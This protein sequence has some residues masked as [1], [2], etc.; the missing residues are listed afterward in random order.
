MFGGSEVTSL[1]HIGGFDEI[2]WDGY[3]IFIFLRKG[4]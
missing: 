1:T 2:G 4:I 3:M